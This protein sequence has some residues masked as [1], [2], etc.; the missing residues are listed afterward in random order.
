MKKIKFLLVALMTCMTICITMPN[1]EVEV[2]SKMTLAQ[3]RAKFPH[4]KYWNHIGS[5]KNNPDGWT[6]TPCT[7]HGYKGAGCSYTGSCGCNNVGS[8]HDAIQ[9]MG[10]AYKLGIDAFGSNPYYW[11]TYTGSSAKKYLY[12]NLKPGDV[13]RIN[14]NGHS[15]FITG[16]S[17]NTVTYTDCNTG[18]TCVIRWGKTMSKAALASKLTNIRE[19][20]ST[21]SKYGVTIS[22]D[23]NDGKGNIK[24]HSIAYE[25][26]ITV[27]SSTAFKKDGYTLDGYYLYRNADKKYYTVENG[28]QNETAIEENDYV[29]KVYYGKDSCFVGEEWTD[30]PS[31]QNKFTFIARW[32][33]NTFTISYDAN[34]GYGEMNDTLV[35]YDVETTL[36]TNVFSNK[37]YNFTGW[38]VYSSEADK[39][40]YTNGET[41]K[42]YVEGKQPEG[43]SKVI[44][45]NNQSVI[46]T[47]PINNDIVKLYTIWQPNKFTVTFCDD[48]EGV[49]EDITVEYGISSIINNT[50]T[51]EGYTFAG[52]NVYS[53]KLCRW[54]YVDEGELTYYTSKENPIHVNIAFFNTGTDVSCLTV[55]S[56][57]VLR[58]HPIWIKEK[59]FDE[60]FT[61]GFI[62]NTIRTLIAPELPMLKG[63]NNTIT[64]V[65]DIIF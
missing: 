27:S 46:K 37:G 52:W 24:A 43:Y 48:V 23:N 22:Y 63:T 60:D 55:V 4:G 47:S 8:G 53:E 21:L 56:D 6:N 9:C 62:G 29:K 17:S 34:E 14:N 40:L 25:N 19:A 33:A 15:I 41:S 13:V 61:L 12:N 31:K 3:L 42:W 39:W 1:T 49:M 36:A 2:A 32:K 30:K 28:W 7:H 58:M 35:T 51:K 50:Y 20:P 64:R 38:N 5:K 45:E 59:E 57:D 10:Y 54:L 18:A 65:T 11:K 16:V 44:Y 26:K